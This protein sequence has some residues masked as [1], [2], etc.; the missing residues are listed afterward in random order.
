MKHA[1]LLAA[2][3]FG[4]LVFP[5]FGALA[6]QADSIHV[7]NSYAFETAPGQ[8]NGAVFMEI[9]NRSPVADRL[10]GA[11]TDVSEI[12]ELHTHIHENGNIAMRQVE[13]ME[14]AG[15]GLLVLEPA[16]NHV[17]L[18]GLKAPLEVGQSVPLTL[19]FEQAGD[20]KAD[21]IIQSLSEPAPETE[22]EADAN[23]HGHDHSH[24]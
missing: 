22:A 3:A 7:M 9:T 17:M 24:E 2:A 11:S 12:V 10:I 14:V 16:G 8:K 21:A 13:A 4:C 19:H 6:Q 23:M 20:I 15:G 18:M 1:I 5:S